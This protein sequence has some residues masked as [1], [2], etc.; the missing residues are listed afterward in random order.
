MKPFTTAANLILGTFLTVFFVINSAFFAEANNLT[1]ALDIVNDTVISGWAMGDTDEP[2]QITVTITNAAG[3]TVQSLNDQADSPRADLVAAGKGNGEYGFSI[4]PDWESL[5]D[6]LYTV[7]AYADGHEL[8]GGRHYMKGQPQSAGFRSLGT[9]KLT[10]YCPCYSCSEGWGR[11]T[12]TGA[13]AS[14]KHTI[15]VDPKVIPYGSKVLINGIVYTAE[16]RGGGVRGNHI[17]VFYDTH[18]ETKVQGTQYQEVFL[19]V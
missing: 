11:N 4:T 16:D 15:A 6:G 1:G 13:I 14:A 19:I 3:Q 17:D 7:R 10:G 18:Q 8:P 9:F 2:A 12:S 5:E